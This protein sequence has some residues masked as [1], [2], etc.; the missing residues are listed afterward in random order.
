M[1]G[2]LAEAG[3]GLILVGRDAGALAA[4]K[5]ELAGKVDVVMGDVSTPEGAKAACRV[6]LSEPAD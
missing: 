2:A 6:A 5:L 3:A 4:A 1:A